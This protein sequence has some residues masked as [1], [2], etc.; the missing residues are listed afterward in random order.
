MESR[1]IHF[2]NM[3]KKSEE[4]LCYRKKTRNNIEKETKKQ[5]LTLTNLDMD[6]QRREDN[7]KLYSLLDKTKINNMSDEDYE[8]IIYPLT[9]DSYYHD[10][11]IGIYNMSIQRLNDQKSFASCISISGNATAATPTNTGYIASQYSEYFPNTEK[12]KTIN[13]KYDRIKQIED[14]INYLN[15]KLPYLLPDISNSFKDAIC[16]INTRKLYSPTCDQF[17]GLRTLIYHELYRDYN[18]CTNNKYA[19][20][21]FIYGCNNSSTTYETLINE[22]CAIWDKISGS[23]KEGKTTEYFNEMLFTDLFQNFSEIIKAR[24]KNH[25]K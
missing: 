12:V 25:R 14:N 8:T 6:I 16:N 2:N 15:S 23:V 9:H 1:S 4:D 3:L 18:K 7:L 11:V 24:L 13:Q 17:V 19:I 20:K 10:N 22:A 21:M 5:N